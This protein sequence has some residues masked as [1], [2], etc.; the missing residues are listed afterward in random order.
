MVAQ[1]WREFRPLNFWHLLAKGHSGKLFFELSLPPR[2]F[3]GYELVCESKESL[4][5]QFMRVNAAFDQVN[6]NAVG[7]ASL[8]MGQPADSAHDANR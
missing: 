1:R 2:V 3:S 4:P 6:Q 7:A 8:G 5:F